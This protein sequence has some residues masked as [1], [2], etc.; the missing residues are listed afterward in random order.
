MKIKPKNKKANILV[1]NIIFII[2]N[3]AF[4]V[5]LLVFLTA[6]TSS[7]A[8]LE[9]RY[10]KEVALLIDSAEPGMLIQINMKKAI[11]KKEKS[12]S[13]DEILQIERN[14]VRVQLSKD[15]GYEY[16]FFND[17][18]VNPVF[19]TTSMEDYYFVIK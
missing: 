12:I 16:S 5:I 17:V 10:A 4:I 6:K 2:L 14:I 18:S 11:N 7:V 19:N 13:S 3:L 1:E 8:V 9:E 15:T